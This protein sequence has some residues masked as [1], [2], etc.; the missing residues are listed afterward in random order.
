MTIGKNE[1]TF[2]WKNYTKPTPA[3]LERNAGLLMGILGTASGIAQLQHYP[4]VGIIL[5]FSIGVVQ[6]FTKFFA[7]VAMAEAE[8]ERQEKEKQNPAL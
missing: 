7:S 2:S 5:A 3:N 6:Q 4:L 8:R 1:V